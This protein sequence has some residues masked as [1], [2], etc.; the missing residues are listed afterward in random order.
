MSHYMTVSGGL[1]QGNVASIPNE[2]I[3]DSFDN[4][5]RHHAGGLKC[6]VNRAFAG[7]FFQFAAQFR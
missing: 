1:K 5:G 6:T 7:D 4:L 3:G 2:V